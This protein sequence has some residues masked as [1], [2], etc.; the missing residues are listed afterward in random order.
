MTSELCKHGYVVCEDCAFERGQMWAVTLLEAWSAPCDIP[1]A[2]AERGKG[3]VERLAYG[4]AA[5]DLREEMED[6]DDS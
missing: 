4:I 6:G 3:S 1:G 2:R 5:E